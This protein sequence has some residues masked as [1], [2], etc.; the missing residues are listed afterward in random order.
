M[1]DLRDHKD[2]LNMVLS[3]GGWM[4]DSEAWTNIM[5]TTET[6]DAF[7]REAI[8]FL[9][10]HDFDGIDLDWQYPAFRGSTHEDQAKFVEFCEVQKNIRWNPITHNY[11][12]K[13]IPLT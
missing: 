2:D 3:V 12:W 5:R 8:V 6:M 10:F 9:R 7:V 13:I 1:N 11:I 4:M